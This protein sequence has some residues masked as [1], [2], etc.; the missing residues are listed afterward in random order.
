M[1]A[2]FTR[3]YAGNELDP[4]SLRAAAIMNE[5]DWANGAIAPDD[6]I[7][8]AA[9][10]RVELLAVV[11]L[12]A[13]GDSDLASADRR[14]ANDIKT[15]F[16]T[17][18]DH[19]AVQQ[20]RKL[21]KDNSGFAAS[22]AALLLGYSAPPELSAKADATGPAGGKDVAQFIDALR[23]F[24]QA[25]QF[26][27]FFKGHR[28]FYTSV[29]RRAQQQAAMTRGY[30][31][32]YTGMPLPDRKLILSSLEDSNGLGKCGNTNRTAGPASVLSLGALARTSE[33]ETFLS[34]EGAKLAFET[35]PVAEK[36]ARSAP[37]PL[38]FD[39]PALQE[40][41]IRAVF[42]R[43]TA[44]SKGDAAGRRAVEQEVHDGFAMVPSLN[45]RLRNYETHR[46]QFATLADFLPELIAGKA[47][48][49]A[50]GGGA[51][52]GAPAQ[53]PVQVA[54]TTPANAVGPS[55][56]Q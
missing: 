53:C 46:D 30:W 48:S 24:A 38:K 26:A 16:A 36:K 18:A 41:L 11:Q 2:A 35:S 37:P 29:T 43:I 13:N 54:A 40:Q 19:A 44:L 6:G 27:R 12:L 32:A 1:P 34:T 31:E 14:Y 15:Y 39:D 47:S 28:P 49:R 21:S 5:A 50:V 8:L 10:A 22:T 45:E 7:Q 55:S 56:G 25:S 52:K 23:D 4:A 3:R 9:D 42:A 51:E 33:A 20:F 17:E